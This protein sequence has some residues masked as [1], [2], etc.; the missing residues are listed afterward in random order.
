MNMSVESYDSSGVI[1]RVPETEVTEV[2]HRKIAEQIIDDEVCQQNMREFMWKY[3]GHP[4]KHRRL[5]GEQP[6]IKRTINQIE[7][8]YS[9]EIFTGFSDE[10]DIFHVR[11]SAGMLTSPMGYVVAGGTVRHGVSEPVVHKSGTV[12]GIEPRDIRLQLLDRSAMDNAPWGHCP[13]QYA[14]AYDQHML[15]VRSMDDGKRHVSYREGRER[16]VLLHPI[17]ALY[18]SIDFIESERALLARSAF[19]LVASE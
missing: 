18:A 8:E 5:A 4:D 6:C 1:E 15:Y 11:A 19:Q 16:T 3:V 17:E 12:G 14:Q 13:G 7:M 10:G 2:L 9:R